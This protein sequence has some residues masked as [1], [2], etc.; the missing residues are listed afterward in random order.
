MRQPQIQNASLPRRWDRND[1]L[2][3]GRRLALDWLGEMRS[4]LERYGLDVAR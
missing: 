1:E 4:A 2:P 3:N